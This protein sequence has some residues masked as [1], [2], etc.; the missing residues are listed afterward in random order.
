MRRRQRVLVAADGHRAAHILG[1]TITDRT[2][3]D[4]L[5]DAADA[6]RRRSESI[7][8]CD[9]DG[10]LTQWA[11]GLDAQKSRDM[12]ELAAAG[13]MIDMSALFLLDGTLAATRQTR[14]RYGWSWVLTDTAAEA[15]GRRFLSTSRA[16]SGQRRYDS[17]RTKGVTIGALRVPGRVVLTCPDGATGLSGCTSVSVAT[18]AQSDALAEG[19]YTVLAT[20]TGPGADR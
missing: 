2:A 18:V 11:N 8:R 15:L 13:G 1:M 16:R 12:A 17:D 20:D 5:A 14:G 19:R 4:H 10:V 6:E 3:A 7:E 9:T